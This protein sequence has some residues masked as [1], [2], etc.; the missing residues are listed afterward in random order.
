VQTPDGSLY[1]TTQQGGASDLG[2]IYRVD[3]QGTVTIVHSFDGTDGQYPIAGL[4][5]G[6]DG[7]LYGVTQQGGT[8][9]P[10]Q[11]SPVGTV[12]RLTLSGDFSTLHTFTISALDGVGPNGVLVQA[13]DGAFYGA[14]PNGNTIFRI[15]PNG[16]FSVVHRFGS[17]AEGGCPSRALTLG[18]DGNLYGATE[19]DMSDGTSGTI[20]RMDLAGDVTVLHKFA[21]YSDTCSCYPEGHGPVLLTEIEPGVFLGP[22]NAGLHS[23]GNIVRITADG[24]F[25]VVHDFAALDSS[26]GYQP[27]GNAPVYGG[28]IQGPDAAFY[29]TTAFGGS[30]NA[31]T[32]FRFVPGD[33]SL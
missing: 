27:E 26:L 22:T 13:A 9:P 19:C 18:S 30:G 25:A 29:G 16:D 14:A 6:A 8:P 24:Q 3:R 31:G 7:A 20:F 10:G 33:G 1:G 32:V 21:G 17:L 11:S 23:T 2:T 28:L 15:F 5:L 4:T 12:F